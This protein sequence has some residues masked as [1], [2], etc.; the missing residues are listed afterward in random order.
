M[1][2]IKDQDRIEALRKRL[3]ERGTPAT[4]A[5][6]H[7][8]TDIKAPAPTAWQA[9]PKPI[10][11]APVTE[12]ITEPNPA[13]DTATMAP[14]KAK[15]KYRLKLFLAGL[16]FF[17]L[18][19]AASSAFMIFGNNSISG[20]NIT[21]A[22]TGPFTVGG[23]E[24]LPIQVGITNS[25]A[26]P[27]ESATLIVEYPL[28]TLSADEARTELFT[29]RLSLETVGSG[30]TVNIPLR[31][32][33]FGEENDEKNVNVSIEY[34]VQGSNAT[35]FKEADPLRF[36]ISSSPILMKVDA[37]KKISSG[38]ET[39][40]TITITSNAPTV[41]SDVLVK[42]EYPLGFDFTSSEPSPASGKN[43]WHITDL[44]P[45]ETRT[46]TITG[47]V[48]GKETDEYAINFTVGVPSDRNPQ[49]LA[50]VFA[51]AQTGFVIEQPFLAINLEIAGVTNGDVVVEPGQQSGASIEIKNTLQDTLYDLVVEVEL[52]GNALSDLEVGPPNGFYDSL[53]NKI[54]WDVSNAP[55][56][57][58]LFPGKST[59]L[60]FG[61]TPS[62][63][64]MRTPQITLDVNV[65]AR[66]VSET[67]VA[68]T[69]LGTAQSV[70]KVASA[71]QVRADIG[72]NTGIFSDSGAVPPAA[73]K[74]TT[75]TISLM[76]ENGSNDITDAVVTAVMPSYVKWLDVTSGA[77]DI[78]YDP[79]QRLVTWSIGTMDANASTFG[80]FQVSF[81]PSKSQIGT[82]PTLLGDQRLKANDRFTGTVVRD[83][84]PAVTTEMSA[85]ANQPKD[86]GRVIP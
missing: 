85:E 69:L 74:P 26:V 28:G 71:P 25:N 16:I 21:I 50:S 12:A 47:I 77:G 64:I 2:G 67:R 32:L 41:L 55:E 31:A 61:L 60:S 38:Q 36:K 79:V 15:P 66:R 54:I 58:E 19:V 37:L 23:G 7:T 39:D 53:N 4:P 45:E 52:G 8:L 48:V 29:E 72:H 84:S 76:A 70:I 65:T 73:E 75:Y 18:A 83:V 46:I 34:R 1:S 35:F 33:V 17:V 63:D 68:E 13:T 27:I 56:L 40:V 44:K 49:A 3:Y 86:N 11:Q 82:T 42:A 62:T 51:T 81:T 30:E 14:K 59:R 6:K 24:T 10:A 20:E 5:Q 43:L 78:V 9:P 80:S 22:V 57:A